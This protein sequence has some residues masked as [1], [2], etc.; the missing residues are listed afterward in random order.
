MSV[1][2]GD[3]SPFWLLHASPQLQLLIPSH[4]HHPPSSHIPT[5]SCPAHS[6]PPTHANFILSAGIR[7]SYFSNLSTLTLIDYN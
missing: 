4:S 3:V 1:Q 5:Q 6:L 2:S 7:Q